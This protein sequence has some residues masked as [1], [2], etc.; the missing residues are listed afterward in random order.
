MLKLFKRAAAYLA[1]P[2]SSESTAAYFGI[3]PTAAKID[4]T[5]E[6]ALTLSAVWCAINVIADSIGAMPV[7][8]FVPRG[9]KIEKDTSSNLYWLVHE[10]PNPAMSATTFIKTMVAHAVSWGNGFAEIQRGERGEV[11]G[12]WLIPP[13]RMQVHIGDDDVPFYVYSD[14]R[15]KR[16]Y[17][18]R[19]E[20][21]HILGP[22]YD[23]LYGRSVVSYARETIAAGLASDEYIGSVIGSGGTPSGIIKHSGKLNDERRRQIAQSWEASH[24]GSR[25]AGRIAV[26]D[27]DF[28]FTPLSMSPADAQFLQTRQFSILEIARWFK[29][30]PSKLGDYRQAKF[31]NLEM[32]EASFLNHSLLPWI[33]G[34]EQELNNKLFP[35]GPRYFKLNFDALL[36]TDTLTRYRAHEV[37]IRNGILTID[38]ARKKEDLNP[39]PDGLGSQHLM[40]ANTM[41]LGQRPESGSEMVNPTQDEPDPTDDEPEDEP[42][43]EDVEDVEAAAEDARGILAEYT[44]HFADIIRRSVAKEQKI[45]ATNSKRTDTQHGWRD[46]CAGF[47]G[48]Q[49]PAELAGWSRNAVLGLVQRVNGRRV[50]DSDLAL[51]DA[52]SAD[53]GKRYAA[54]AGDAVLADRSAPEGWSAAHVVDVADKLTRRAYFDVLMAS[55]PAVRWY[56]DGCECGECG[57]NHGQIV[58]T[59]PTC[60]AILL[61]AKEVSHGGS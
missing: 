28:N 6:K 54:A 26:M 4:V 27:V 56:A 42:E 40:P 43:A 20:V 1:G 59:A 61:P 21:L 11:T 17:L 25:K 48:R 51:V 12:L 46:W 2:T 15:G 34:L 37:G 58:D 33:K 49:H 9:D 30:P 44:L 35:R 19:D 39:V 53:F 22:S 47:Y 7:Q 60:G 38:E 55:S 36:R 32:D 50:R 24:G 45:V 8:I 31:A 10:R 3:G 13:D 29:L 5:Q 14:R 41:V 18:L 16:F 52:V 57:M 23:G